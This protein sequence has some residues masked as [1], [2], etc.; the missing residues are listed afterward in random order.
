[1]VCLVVVGLRCVG[2]FDCFDHASSS[3]L[4]YLHQLLCLATVTTSGHGTLLSLQD[5]SS[6]IGLM[7]QGSSGRLPWCLGVCQI[8]LIS[9]HCPL[10]SSCA[11]ALKAGWLVQGSSWFLLVSRLCC[12]GLMLSKVSKP[13]PWSLFKLFVLTVSHTVYDQQHIL[14][15]YSLHLHPGRFRC[16]QV[17]QV[18]DHYCPYYWHSVRYSLQ[19]LICSTLN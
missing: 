8:V 13:C 3:A 12:I 1:M 4:I 9:P 19:I 11:H 7:V 17:S 10:Q 5:S 14:Y 15:S 16:H 6:G 2:K 18:H